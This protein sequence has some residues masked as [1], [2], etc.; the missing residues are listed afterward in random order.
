M[1]SFGTLLSGELQRMKK[2]NIL[3]VSFLVAL[4][5]IGVLYF[6]EIEDITS[7]VPLLVFIDATSMSMLMVG[8][9]MFYEKQEGTI[10]TLLVSPISKSEYILAKAFANITSNIITIILIYG[11]ARIFK[12]IN[13]NFF[14][15]LSSVILIAFF[16]SL[17][18][19]IF[20]YNTKDF[21]E[22][23]MG[24]MKYIFIFAIPVL[25]EQMGLIK[26]KK[27]DKILYII[28]TKSSSILLKSTAGGL[29]SW[30]IWFSLIYLVIASI[31]LFFIVWKKFDD[32]AI[33]E[34][35]E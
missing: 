35:G 31:L 16:H 22:M 17:V 18:G 33:K 9:T 3:T 26:N 10:K 5:W 4:I 32:F 27:I 25:L 7:V 6:V 14:G 1:N 21:T 23:L 29:E 34:S 15:L 24:M 13:L 11:Y 30:K 12:E 2:Y 28:P 8:A 19:F 20:T